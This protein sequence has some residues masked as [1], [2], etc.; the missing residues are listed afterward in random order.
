MVAASELAEAGAD[1][2]R[3]A[4]GLPVLNLDIFKGQRKGNTVQLT[5]CRNIDQFSPSSSYCGTDLARAE[6][7]VAC[8]VPRKLVVGITLISKP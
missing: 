3:E 4:A 5:K 6:C 2:A 7:C 1:G 8:S